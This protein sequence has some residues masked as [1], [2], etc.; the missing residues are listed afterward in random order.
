MKDIFFTNL[1]WRNCETC[2]PKEVVHHK[3]ILT[4]GVT[5]HEGRY[6]STFGRFYIK[7][8]EDTNFIP[9]N[10]AESLNKW[11]WT[12]VVEKVREEFGED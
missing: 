9:L 7:L 8:W 3:I 2:P 10:T 11:W 5:L 4:D 1:C 12:D 6:H